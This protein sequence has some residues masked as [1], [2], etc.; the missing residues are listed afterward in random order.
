LFTPFFLNIIILIVESIEELK[1]QRLLLK[2]LIGTSPRPLRELTYFS[3][4]STSPE[5]AMISRERSPL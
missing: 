5:P 4:Y 1:V 3:S 2:S